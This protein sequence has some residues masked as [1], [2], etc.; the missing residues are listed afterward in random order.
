[1]KNN[2][3]IKVVKHWNHSSKLITWVQYQIVVIIF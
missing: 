1:M 3:K 2:N